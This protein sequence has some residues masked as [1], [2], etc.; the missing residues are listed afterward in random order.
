MKNFDFIEK[1][2]QIYDPID[3]YFE[4]ISRCDV[5]DGTCISRCVEVLKKDEN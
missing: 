4:C 5:K 3:N 2:F 1:E